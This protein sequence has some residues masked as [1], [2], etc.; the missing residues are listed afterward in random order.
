MRMTTSGFVVHKQDLK[1]FDI[2]VTIFSREHGVIKAVAQKAKKKPHILAQLE[3]FQE[4]VFIIN[5]TDTLGSIYHID[6]I[7][8]FPGI[9]NSYEAYMLASHF[10][11]VARTLLPI[12]MPHPALYSIYRQ[13][14]FLL[15]ENAYNSTQIS[16][17][18]YG[19]VLHAEGLAEEARPVSK[20]HFTKVLYEYCG[21]LIE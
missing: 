14:L 11:V 10:T 3:L 19:A 8:F 17:D 21:V 13:Y 15:S 20:T 12:D 2:L 18:F 1:D 16:A 7:V 6:P 4:S 5:K 9:R